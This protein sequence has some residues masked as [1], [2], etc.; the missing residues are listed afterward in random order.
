MRLIRLACC[1]L[2]LLLAPAHAQQPA[3]MTEAQREAGIRDA[4]TA[5][6]K[7]AQDGPATVPLLDQAKLDLPDDMVFVPAAETLALLR[8]FG[9]RPDERTTVGLVTGRRSEWSVVVRFIKE[10]YVRD[11]DA[12]EWNADDLLASLREGNA[13]TNRERV[14]RGFPEMELVGWLAPPAYD[15]A[16]HRLVWA[17]A[18]KVKGVP[19]GGERNVNYNTYALGRDGYFSLNLLTSSSRL[20]ADKPVAAALLAALHYD[21]GRRYEDF[22]AGTD[23]VAEYGLAALVGAVAAKKLGLFA[24]IAAFVAKFAKVGVLAVVGLGAAAARLFRRKGPSA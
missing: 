12:K 9:N 23:R 2:A 14:Q 3:P 21:P 16:T 10:G 13:E 8:A 5:A 15:T 24:V 22:A 4:W 1:L 6:A 7:A 11:D 19:D 20:E 17:L 18:S